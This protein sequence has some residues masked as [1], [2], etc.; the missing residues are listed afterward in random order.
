LTPCG[1]RQQS[2][3]S[4]TQISRTLML[5]LP[6]TASSRDPLQPRGCIFSLPYRLRDQGP[7]HTGIVSSG[8]V[9]VRPLCSKSYTA[10]VCASRS[11]ATRRKRRFSSNLLDTTR[12]SLYIDRDLVSARH[13][14]GAV[15]ISFSGR[16]VFE[17]LASGR[18]GRISC[19]GTLPITLD[20]SC[21]AAQRR[22][23]H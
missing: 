19:L 3:P 15:E 5:R 9:G 21:A 6:A 12:H 4:A 8:A 23:L 14:R 18:T 2:P 1:S 11:R 13:S 22:R 16:F 7:R 17:R 20:A 10:P